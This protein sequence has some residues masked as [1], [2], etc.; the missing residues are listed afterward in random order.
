MTLETLEMMLFYI[1]ST[2]TVA[3]F[4]TSKAIARLMSMLL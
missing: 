4:A 2:S 1:A 3:K